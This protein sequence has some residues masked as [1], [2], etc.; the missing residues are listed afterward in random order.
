MDVPIYQS[1]RRIIQR[2]EGRDPQIMARTPIHAFAPIEAVA[3]VSPNGFWI[4][5][6]AA[7][8]PERI[9]IA[10]PG[11][12]LVER[13]GRAYLRIPKIAG[14]GNN[15]VLDADSINVWGKTGHYGFRLRGSPPKPVPIPVPVVVPPP[16]APAPPPPPP[17]LVLTEAG[18]PPGFLF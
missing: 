15:L 14:L 11:S 2:I 10:P 8:E 17:K 6:D 16:P 3:Q 4:E 7:F 5:V 13:Q 9:V 18:P 12:E 1:E